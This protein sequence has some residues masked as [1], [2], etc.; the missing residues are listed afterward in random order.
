MIYC[1]HSERLIHPQVGGRGVRRRGEGG[2][3]KGECG[4]LGHGQYFQHIDGPGAQRV[5]L[6]QWMGKGCWD[7]EL[8]GEVS[9]WK[10]NASASESGSVLPES[11]SPSPP[12]PA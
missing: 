12:F 11:E 2:Q 3:G 5:K 9:A 4:F 10:K 7:G 6:K 1:S 8:C